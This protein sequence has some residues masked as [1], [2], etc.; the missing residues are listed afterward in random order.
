MKTFF[1]RV[2]NG[3]L[4]S[5]ALIA[6]ISLLPTALRADDRI[7][8]DR[9]HNDDHHWDNREDQAYR[10]WVRDRHRRYEDFERLREHDRRAYWNWRHQHSD[11]VLRINI[12]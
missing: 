8:H 2:L 7:Y 6:P 12:H 3:A 1:T 10:I 5:A 4:L 9:Y 11:E